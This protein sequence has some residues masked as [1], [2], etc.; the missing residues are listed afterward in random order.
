MHR[1]ETKTE[2]VMKILGNEPSQQSKS[3]KTNE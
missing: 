2:S 1:I 3:M